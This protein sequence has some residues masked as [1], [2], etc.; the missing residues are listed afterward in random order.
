MYHRK[1][2]VPQMYGQ[3]QS[4]VFGANSPVLRFS[5]ITGLIRALFLN[6][7][8]AHLEKKIIVQI[9]KFRQDSSRSNKKSIRKK[10]ILSLTSRNEI[11]AFLVDDHISTILLHN[12]RR[13]LNYHMSRENAISGEKPSNYEKLYPGGFMAS[14]KC[15][16]C[17]LRSMVISKTS[18]E[19]R[20]FSLSIEHVLIHIARKTVLGMTVRN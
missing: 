20:P 10:R 7:P 17:R 16:N 1:C 5:L 3:E 6:F 12:P 11:F 14:S 4:Q 15:A 18:I 13:R 9:C 8:D 2:T 19:R